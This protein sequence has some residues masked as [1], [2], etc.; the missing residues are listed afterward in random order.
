MGAARGR[1]GR[2][3]I[4]VDLAEVLAAR[5]AEV[6]GAV[7]DAIASQVIPSSAWLTAEHRRSEHA[8]LRTRWVERVMVA[9]A[10]GQRLSDDDLRFYEGLGVVF[11]RQSVPL[12]LLTAAF[13]VGTAVLTRESWRIAPAGCLAEMTWFTDSATRI[14]RHALQASTR[15]Y[16]A[17]RQTAGDRRPWPGEA[18]IPPD[19]GRPAVPPPAGI[20]RWSAE[21]REGQEVTRLLGELAGVVWVAPGLGNQE[22]RTMLDGIYAITAQLS[23]PASDPR[24]VASLWNA[25]NVAVASSGA[26]GMTP[27]ARRITQLLAL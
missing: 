23:S 20:R 14:A 26:A 25:V 17:S 2:R 5:S 15:A 10:A 21:S 1:Y 18:L 6:A 19:P 9:A 12:R 7:T 13:D 3:L 27:L 4:R 11:G 24:L 8:G 22:R 16:L